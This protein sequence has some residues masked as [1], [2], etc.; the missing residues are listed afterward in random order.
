MPVTI[1]STTTA[2]TTTAAATTTT[3]VAAE[4][5]TTTIATTTTTA[6]T[7]AA[8]AT[9]TTT[10]SFRLSRSYWVTLN[11]FLRCTVFL[12][13]MLVLQHS[14]ANA[15]ELTR[16]MQ[17]YTDSSVQFSSRWYLCARKS[18]YA[19]HPV[20]QKLPQRCLSGGSNVRL[21][22]DG[23][24]LLSNAFHAMEGLVARV[25]HRLYYPA[26]WGVTCHLRGRI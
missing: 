13:R 2:T 6:A 10:T 15:L 19:L 26:T 7:A 8:A 23:S 25:T 20:S 21:T 17:L 5:G 16:Y 11:C 18:P 4:A 14:T 9:T 3:T 1:I 24:L 12:L 22:D